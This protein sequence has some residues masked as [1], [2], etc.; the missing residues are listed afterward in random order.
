MELL[1]MEPNHLD[2]K[3]RTSTKIVVQF[4]IGAVFGGI[5]IYTFFARFWVFTPGTNPVQIIV[6][7]LAVLTC[8]TISAVWGG[9]GLDWLLTAFQSESV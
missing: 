6:S 4:L 3:P 9:K 7:V 1:S 8:G 2:L 5:F